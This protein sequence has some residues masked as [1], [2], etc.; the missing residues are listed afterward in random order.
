MMKTMILPNDIVQ[1]F[2]LE[3][4]EG[5]ILRQENCYWMNTENDTCCPSSKIPSHPAGP[6]HLL[7]QR[8][9]RVRFAENHQR[10]EILS[11]DDF[12][13]AEIASSWYS[14]KE[15][16]AISAERTKMLARLEQGKLCNEDEATYRGL[17]C[18][19]TTGADD[20]SYNINRVIQAVIQEQ[21]RQWTAG[22]NLDA[23]L[24]ASKSQAVTYLSL[25]RAFELAQ[26][27]ESEATRINLGQEQETFIDGISWY[28]PQKRGKRRG[29]KHDVLA[30]NQIDCRRRRKSR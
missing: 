21:Q 9:T 22:L 26:T 10:H 4:K 13:T 3:N 8:S 15:K 24:I 20:L 16:K 29:V 2:D 27:D 17:E 6:I 28:R 11:L 14:S 1:E 5:K 23:K 25:Q 18:W 30:G 12:S 19:T 7:Q